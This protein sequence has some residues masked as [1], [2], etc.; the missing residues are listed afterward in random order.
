MNKI[1]LILSFILFLFYFLGGVFVLII[2]NNFKLS[3][4]SISFSFF[5][6]YLSYFFKSKLK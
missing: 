1:N 4:Y 3:G 6:L 5:W 2:E